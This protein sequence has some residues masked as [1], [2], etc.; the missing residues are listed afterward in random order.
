MCLNIESSS[1]IKVGAV[2]HAAEKSEKAINA[3]KSLYERIGG[4]EAV[5]AAVG[6][7]YKKMLADAKVSHFFKNIDMTK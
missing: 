3:P 6:I 2:N 1:A 4:E 7:F 5:T